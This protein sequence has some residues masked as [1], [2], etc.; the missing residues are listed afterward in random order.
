MRG[1][2]KGIERDERRKEE[3][4]ECRNSHEIKVLLSFTCQRFSS[5]EIFI[6]FC[7]EMT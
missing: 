2:D 3:K 4:R 5:N 1:R 7:L 6:N